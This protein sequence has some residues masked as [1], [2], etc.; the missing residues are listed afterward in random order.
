VG[1][2][3]CSKTGYR[4]RLGLYE[5]MLTS[6]EIERLTVERVSSD[7]IKR[8][9]VKDGMITLRQEGLE[10][11]RLGLTSLQEVLRVVA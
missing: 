1:C 4:G 6:E 9:A 8:S 2:A 3:S 10:K 5:V 11:V 7:V